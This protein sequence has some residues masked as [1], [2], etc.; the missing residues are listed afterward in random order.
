MAPEVGDPGG[1]GAHAFVLPANIRLSKD[2][3]C[4]SPISR[5]SCAAYIFCTFVP[6]V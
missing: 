5:A 3:F 2:G 4:I 6:N 1:V